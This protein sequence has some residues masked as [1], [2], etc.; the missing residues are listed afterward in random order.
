MLEQAAAGDGLRW[1]H[2][3]LADV[4]VLN[5]AL[6]VDDKSRPLGQFV[7]RSAHLF[8]AHRNAILLKHLEIWVTQERKSNVKLLREGSVR[9]RTV[10][11]DTEHDGVARIQL[12]PIS[13]I[14]FE[15][16][17]SSFGK[18]KHVEDENDVLLP[19][20][21][22][23]LDLFPVI[24]EKREIGSLVSRPQ[25]PCGRGLSESR[26]RKGSG[27]QDHHPGEHSKNLHWDLS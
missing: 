19:S 11:T 7:A 16:T 21:I 25:D 15:F 22:A 18:R 20:E 2:R 6:F 10:T 3:V 12:W 14:G 1:I 23:E 8:Q 17:A 4:D 27:E 5:D 9:R 13:L 26:R 24:A